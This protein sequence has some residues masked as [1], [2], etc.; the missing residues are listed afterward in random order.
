MSLRSH[1][2]ASGN[3]Q[4]TDDTAGT[5]CSGTIAPSESQ[6]HTCARYYYDAAHNVISE[7]RVR[8]GTSLAPRRIAVSHRH[9]DGDRSSSHW[10]ELALPRRLRPCRIF[11]P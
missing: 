7:N 2:T 6:P 9:R 10:H 5:A 4:R 3:A 8:R 11:R 1:V